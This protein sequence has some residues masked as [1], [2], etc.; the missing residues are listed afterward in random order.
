[1]GILLAVQTH[2]PIIVTVLKEPTSQVDI[3]DVLVGSLG[4]AGVLVLGAAVLGAVVAVGMVIWKRLHPP[5]ADHL[6]SVTQNP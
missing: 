4:L 6:P 1:M 5:E 2:G 3:G